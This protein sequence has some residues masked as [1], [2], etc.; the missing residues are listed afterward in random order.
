MVKK[1]KVVNE[2]FTNKLQK[3]WENGFS[4]KT[5]KE[6]LSSGLEI[7]DAG[8]AR[9]LKYVKKFDAENFL[10]LESKRDLRKE[11]E[12]FLEEVKNDSKISVEIIKK[13]KGFM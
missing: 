12:E 4:I 1:W 6:W 11:Y 8:Y 13:I 5:C 7:T 3:D 10:N 2:K 9:W